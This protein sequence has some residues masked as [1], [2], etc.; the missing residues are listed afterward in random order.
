M[1][2]YISAVLSGVLLYV[3]SLQNL[4]AVF[5]SLSVTLM[6]SRVC[7]SCLAVQSST[8]VV[9]YPGC[10]Y[11]TPHLAPSYGAALYAPETVHQAAMMPSLTLH[12]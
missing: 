12:A 2:S 7:N 9:V 4:V 10:A 3:R 1:R 11:L 6:D 8:A 5:E